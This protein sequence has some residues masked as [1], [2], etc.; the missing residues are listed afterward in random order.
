M[1]LPNITLEEAKKHKNVYV[2]FEGYCGEIIYL[3]CPVNKV[4]C[5]DKELQELL[6]YIEENYW[7]DITYS[8]VY[9]EIVEDNQKNIDGGMGGGKLKDEL[10]IHPEISW[11]GIPEKIKE[12][13]CGND[14]FKWIKE[15]LDDYMVIEFE[16]YS[17]D[18]TEF[19]TNLDK[20]FDILK[21]ATEQRYEDLKFYELVELMRNLQRNDEKKNI[22]VVI[23]GDVSLDVKKFMKIIKD[24]WENDAEKHIPSRKYRKF[25]VEYNEEIYRLDDFEKAKET[26]NAYVVFEG[27]TGGMTYITCPLSK[28]QCNEL[29]LQELL[30]YIDKYCYNKISKARKYYVLKNTDRQTLTGAMLNNNLWIHPE[31][32]KYNIEEKIRNTINKKSDSEKRNY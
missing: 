3:T 9:F 29:E 10:W 18:W 27:N 1:E 31:I 8:R 23:Y 19:V 16:L 25:I 26:E 2:I 21:H 32:L 17:K 4:K 12:T 24:F 30:E 11:N 20:K 13:I 15:E 14:E 28:I 7:N 22:K 6:K 5:N